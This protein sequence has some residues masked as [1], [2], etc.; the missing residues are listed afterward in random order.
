MI[1]VF[2]LKIKEKNLSWL[3]NMTTKFQVLIGE[4]RLHQILKPGWV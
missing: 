2:D 4:V 3:K 1:Q